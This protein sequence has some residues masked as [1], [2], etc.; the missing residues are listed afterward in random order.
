M[1]A[2]YTGMAVSGVLSAVAILPITQMLV[3]ETALQASMGLED[4]APMRLYGAALVK[5]INIIALLMVPLL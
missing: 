3:P 4:G 5:V 1:K 2:L